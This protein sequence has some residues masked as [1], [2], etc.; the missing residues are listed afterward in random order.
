MLFACIY[1]DD[2]PRTE[3]AEQIRQQIISGFSAAAAFTEIGDRS[4][5][6]CHAVQHAGSQD[7][8]LVAGKGHEAYQHI[9][10]VRHDYQ[11]SEQVIKAFK[12]RAA[13]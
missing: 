8:I 6:I 3:S 7:V 13:M 12:L 2:N 11:D 1:T 10:N 9:G 4:Q 5:A